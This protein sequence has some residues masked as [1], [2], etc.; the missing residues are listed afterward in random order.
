MRKY[1]RTKG[2]I[3]WSIKENKNYKSNTENKIDLDQ[4]YDKNLL[5]PWKIMEKKL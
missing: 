4:A 2:G 3:S 5:Q 1:E